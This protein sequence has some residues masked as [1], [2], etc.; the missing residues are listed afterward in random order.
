[1]AFTKCFLRQNGSLATRKATAGNE[2]G[3]RATGLIGKT[4][5]LH[6]DH[7]FLYISLQLLHDYNVKLPSFTYYGGREHKTTMFF[8][9]FLDLDIVL[10]NQL[11]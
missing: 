4:T 3:R 2:N 7:A 8:S 1:M 10:L 11:Q 6:V 9:F 5:T